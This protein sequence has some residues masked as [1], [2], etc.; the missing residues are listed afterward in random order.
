MDQTNDQQ[1]ENNE[2]PRCGYCNCV[3][4]VKLECRTCQTTDF[5]TDCVDQTFDYK[6]AMELY[7]FCCEE[8]HDAFIYS[9]R[10]V[11]CICCHHLI[12]PCEVQR[13][14]YAI[15]KL[16]IPCLVLS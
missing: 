11:Q 3:K 7:R 9:D 6:N 2:T 4:P 5:C 12:L 16:C 10:C 1:L 13:I 14:D 15:G 8:C